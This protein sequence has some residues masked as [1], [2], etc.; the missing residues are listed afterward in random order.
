[1]LANIPVQCVQRVVNGMEVSD[2]LEVVPSIIADLGVGK[3][4]NVCVSS[5]ACKFVSLIGVLLDL[6][7]CSYRDDQDA[8]DHGALD[9]EHH[10]IGSNDTSAH[11]T[12]PQLYCQSQ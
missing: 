1:M 4:S 2:L 9:F 8:Y 12:N 6:R 3:V 7:P 11:K 5:I 10:Q